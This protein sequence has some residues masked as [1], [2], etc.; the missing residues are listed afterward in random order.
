MKK[1]TLLLIAIFVTLS[2][3]SAPP[4]I[5]MTKWNGGFRGLFN[6]YDY[7]DFDVTGDPGSLVITG[8]CADPGWTRC[9]WHSHR[10]T[11]IAPDDL[12]EQ[13]HEAYIN[14]INQLLD[15]TEKVC[16]RRGQLNGNA[17]SNIAFVDSDNNIVKMYSF[18]VIWDYTNEEA[19]TGN[20]DIYPTDIT[21]LL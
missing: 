14:K 7:V 13:Y 1:I 20:I 18:L 10:G 19:T 3:S 5:H 11:M 12:P 15:K 17:S 16:K 2:V 6:L 21:G 9:I 8:A 4:E